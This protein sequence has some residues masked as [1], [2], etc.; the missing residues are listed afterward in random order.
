[1][2]LIKLR[3]YQE[4][5]VAEIRAEFRNGKKCILFVLPTGGGKTYTFSFVADASALKGK[6]VMI[7]VHRKELLKQA[8]KSLRSLGIE[9]G[10]IAPWATPNPRAAVQV[11]SVDALAS[12]LA[13]NRIYNVDF[14][15]F[16]EAHHVLLDNKWGR[17]WKSLGEPLVLGVTATP[18]RGDGKGL[19]AHCGGIFHGMVIGPTPKELVAMGALVAP[20]V[21]G[22]SEPPDVDGVKLDAKGE[23]DTEQLAERTDKPKLIGDAVKHY[24]EVCPGELAVA[25]CVN[26]KHAIHVRDAF[27]AA[28]YKFAL[29]VG[30]PHVSDAERDAVIQQLEA[31]ELDG[32]TTVSLVSEGF[33]VP[34]LVCCLMLRALASEVEF[35][36]QVGRVMRPA[37]GKLHGYLLDHAGNV[38]RWED[39][40]FHVKH[41]L[42]TDE[43]EHSLDGRK[44][45]VR[46]EKAPVDKTSLMQCKECFATFP[47]PVETFEEDGS[48]VLNQM[49]QVAH[50]C[51]PEC[52]ALLPVKKVPERHIDQVDGK[53]G[54]ITEEMIAK[55]AAKVAQGRAATVEDMVRTLGYSQ[56]R[57]EKVYAARIEK[58]VLIDNLLDDFDAFE[59]KTGQ[60][61]L[62]MFQIPRAAIKSM[63]P[64]E[65]KA[66]RERLDGHMAIWS[67]VETPQTDLVF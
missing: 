46:G 18:K 52:H 57:A 28:G 22:C 44:K 56:G 42:P 61:S 30:K 11:A 10:L 23:Y 38:G 13:K 17:V 65:L 27:N 4:K 43:R 48:P 37:E 21:L 19:G 9:H 62:T 55:A 31:G 40:E 24:S 32:I 35:L 25:F 49:G 2:S 58:Q 6:R 15:I 12:R 7:I 29:L 36:Q 54:E 64:R 5:A 3:P 14:I 1:M 26:V 34:G 59:T 41:G 8:S 60:N 20:K 50:Q 16:D 63:K 33:D 53:L 67:N 45:K 39:G 51:C 47:P 66:L